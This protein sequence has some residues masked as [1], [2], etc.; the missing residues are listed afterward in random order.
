WGNCCSAGGW[1]GSTSGYCGT[2]CQAEFGTCG[3]TPPPPPRPP[4]NT[5]F[6]LISASAFSN[7][8]TACGVTQPGIYEGLTRAFPNPLNGGL[9]E[10]A[11]LMGN[12]AHESGAFRF[13]E[14]IACAG[15]T[16][17]TSNCKYGL[18]HGR[19]Y[20]Q[21]SWD[22][23]YRAA[24]NYLNNQQIFTNPNIIMNDVNVNWDT[25]NWFWTTQVEPYLQ[26]NGYTLGNS[27]MAVNGGQECPSS[28]GGNVIAD[29]RVKY[30]QCFEQQ[31]TGSSS[32]STTC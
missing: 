26:S 16:V 14:E 7:A 10:L 24:A 13:V 19:G 31:F 23:N 30:I 28:K 3:P 5:I 18:Y 21:L 12:L 8:L 1:C 17:A 15:V 22:Y 9:K 2:G 11:L 20:M 27:V 29:G 4:V 6:N 32:D 25:V